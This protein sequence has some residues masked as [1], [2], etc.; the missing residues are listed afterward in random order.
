MGRKVFVSVLGTSFYGECQYCRGTFSSSNTRFIQHATLEYL[1]V[2]EQWSD[3]DQIYILLTDKAR[4]NNWSI[5]KRVNP[6]N[7]EEEPY[8]GLNEIISDMKVSCHVED[9]SIPDGSSETEMWTIFTKL[10]DKLETEDELYFDLTHSFRYLPMLVLVLG[11]YAKFLKH[12]SI[13]HI[14]Y[15]NYEA[16]NDSNQA[17]LMDVLP[18]SI[19]QDWTFA[20]ADL[21]R[22]G[23]AESLKLLTDEK[24]L[25]PFIRRKGKKKPERRSV[26]EPLKECVDKLE[27]VMLEFRLCRG[28]EIFHGTNIAEFKSLSERIISNLDVDN[29]MEIISPIPPIINKIRNTF[30]NFKEKDLDNGYRAALWCYDHQLYQQA[31]TILDE[32]ITSV[33]C[34]LVG[35]KRDIYANRLAAGTYLR[36]GEDSLNKLDERYEAPRMKIINMKATSKVQDFVNIFRPIYEWLHEKRNAY[37]H[38][39]IP[40][41]ES[42]ESADLEKLKQIIDLCSH[43]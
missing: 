32:N 15:G 37:N 21:I 24:A 25:A 7:K 12:T 16:R 28:R 2:K 41:G 23:N 6:K 33:F 31:I 3:S 29:D 9:I 18:L 30:E 43:A 11:N 22:N 14:S 1:K 26:E 19:L 42:F 8:I 13:K 10:F 5:E 36:K 40:H 39:S 34:G 20:A 35:L 38:A 27:S 17:P 4:E